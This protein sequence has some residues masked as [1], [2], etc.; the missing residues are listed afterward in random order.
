MPVAA[1]HQDPGSER[2][3]DSPPDIQVV[4]KSACHGDAALLVREVHACVQ[5]LRRAQTRGFHKAEFPSRPQLS[6]TTPVPD[7]SSSVQRGILW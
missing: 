6:H 3:R 5:A 1:S 7:P 4:G 2:Q